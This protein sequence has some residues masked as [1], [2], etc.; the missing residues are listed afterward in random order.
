MTKEIYYLSNG[1]PEN[2]VYNLTS[3]IKRAV[4]SVRLNIREGNTF[5]NK[6]RLAHFQRA[7]GS[8]EEVDECMIIAKELSYITDNQF[9]IYRENYWLCLNML[10]KLI[11]SICSI[12]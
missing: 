10:R 3:Q 12:K 8:I 7:L 2:E 9:I 5:R 4:I 11:S 6:N 1:F